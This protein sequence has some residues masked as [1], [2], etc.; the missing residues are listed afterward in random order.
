MKA[1]LCTIS[2]SRTRSRSRPLSVTCCPVGAM[3][4]NEPGPENVPVALQRTATRSSSAV[5]DSTPNAKSGIAANR[6]PKKARTPSGPSTLVWPIMLSTPSGAQH[7]TAASTSRAVR[8]SKYVVTTDRASAGMGA[9]IPSRA[10]RKPTRRT[11][12]RARRAGAPRRLAAAR[13]AAL[14]RRAARQRLGGRRR[15]RHR[16]VRLRPRRPRADARPRARAGAGRPAGR[17]HPPDRL[18]ARPR[19]PLRP[20]RGAAGADRLRALDPPAPRASHRADRRPRGDAAAA[21][22]DRARRAASR[23]RRCAPGRSAS[24]ARTAG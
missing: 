22:R 11:R 19:R 20:G 13:P 8:A 9:T 21:D 1:S 3:P 5:T 23:R 14:A 2:P 12:G 15:R 24:A 17:G 16:A 4:W 7:A 10:V 18:H 6:S